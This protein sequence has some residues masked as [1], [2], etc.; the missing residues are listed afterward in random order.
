MMKYMNSGN[1]CHI[2]KRFIAL[3]PAAVLMF[4]V[5]CGSGRISESDIS[6]ETGRMFYA[7]VNDKVLKI[8]AEENT[9]AEAFLESPQQIPPIIVEA[10]LETPGKRARICASPIMSADFFVILKASCILTLIFFFSI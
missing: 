7:H 10:A 1:R 3:I 5:L 9:S 4:I 6:E 8:L 2:V